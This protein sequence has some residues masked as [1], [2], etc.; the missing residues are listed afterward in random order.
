MSRYRRVF[1]KIRGVHKNS[2]SN[3]SWRS[4]YR[5]AES[6]LMSHDSENPNF[7]TEIICFLDIDGS[8]TVSVT[9]NGTVIHRVLIG[10]EHPS[11]T[12][13]DIKQVNQIVPLPAALAASN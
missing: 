8:A 3:W 12:E 1:A 4:G 7:R 6:M 13:R 11:A 10:P 9:R 2:Q 5:A